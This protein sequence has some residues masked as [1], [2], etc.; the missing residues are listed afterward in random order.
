M[1]GDIGPF[2]RLLENLIENGL[3]HTAA[4]GEVHVHVEPAGTGVALRIA[5]TGE[6]IPA[7]K[8]AG[9]FDRYYQVDR[10]EMGNTGS[11]GLG[12]A[13]VRRIVALHG[14]TLPWKAKRA[15]APASSCTFLRGKCDVLPRDQKVKLA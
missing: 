14:A 11:S 9:I 10:G 13:I 2:E 8:L 4:G 15:A 3:R 12:L 7:D 6:G 5:D 1:L